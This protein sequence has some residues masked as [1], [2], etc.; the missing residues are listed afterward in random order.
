MEWEK[1]TYEHTLLE[2]LLVV[3]ESNVEPSDLKELV[4]VDINEVEEG[5][6]EVVE[7]IVVFQ[8]AIYSEES[9]EYP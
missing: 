2:V 8:G 6:D 4:H 7:Q 9:N 1:L 3:L 5:E